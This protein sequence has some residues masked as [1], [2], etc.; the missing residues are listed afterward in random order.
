MRVRT[1]GVAVAVLV[2]SAPVARAVA[3]DGAPPWSPG[4][5]VY[6][7]SVTKNIPVTMSDGTVLRV[8]V[9]RPSDL[10]TGAPVQGKDFPVLMTQTPYG[11]G[12]SDPAGSGP[13]TYLISRGYIEVEVDIRGR[14]ASEGNFEAFGPREIQDG[15]EMV[16]WS[17]A[18]SGSN[19]K[20][21]LIGCSYLGINQLLTAE[22]IGPHSPLKAIFP[23]DSSNSNYRD[24]AF[25][26]GMPSAF[27]AV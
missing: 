19:G 5:A 16:G 25:V 14:G 23:Q 24:L 22:A 18:L 12:A 2:A 1:L 6:G 13:D 21:G 11:K 15:V 8:D 9:Y 26:G 17:A 7:V 10:V 3:P 20:V 4:A 27:S